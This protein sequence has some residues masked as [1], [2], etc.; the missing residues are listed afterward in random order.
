[1]LGVRRGLWLRDPSKLLDERLLGLWGA[2]IRVFRV[3][4][5]P[6][7]FL[8]SS[9]SSFL[10]KDSSSGCRIPVIL[11]RKEDLARIHTFW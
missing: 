7:F 8:S 9:R 10:D 6:L 1:M 5:G 11:K 2:P 4:E 3:A